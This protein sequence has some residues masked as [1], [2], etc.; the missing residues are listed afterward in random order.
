MITLYFSRRLSNGDWKGVSLE[1][2]RYFGTECSI[3][4]VSDAVILDRTWMF[5]G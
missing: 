2:R 3:D 4:Q 5:D 1:S